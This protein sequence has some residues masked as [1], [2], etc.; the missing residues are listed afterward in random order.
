LIGD[1]VTSLCADLF[2]VSYEVVLQ[3]LERYFAHTEETD[4]QLGTLANA[5][6]NLMVSVLRPLGDVITTLPIGPG[7][8]QRTAG[9]SF[10]LFYEDDYLLPHRESAWVLL[11]E[12]VRNAASFCAGVMKGPPEDVASALA[13]V[14]GAL[15]GVADSLAQH[16]ADRGGSSRFATGGSSA[17]PSGP[18]EPVGFEQD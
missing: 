1:R 2:N 8:P 7:H 5:A 10:E 17:R 4:A 15:T 11:E 12:R 16:F 3:I 6:V 18:D 14:E 13:P 9:P